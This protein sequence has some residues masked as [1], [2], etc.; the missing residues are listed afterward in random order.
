M[1]EI[2]YCVERHIQ[3]PDVDYKDIVFWD[4]VSRIQTLN[5]Q[6]FNII[7]SDYPQP[8]TKEQA[9]DV[10]K[11]AKKLFPKQVFRVSTL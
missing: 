6:D 2:K 9:E 5:G 11:R 7:K 10:A 4:H 3:N 8:M 1:A